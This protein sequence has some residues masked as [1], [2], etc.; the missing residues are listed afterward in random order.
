MGQRTRRRLIQI[1]GPAPLRNEDGPVWNRGRPGEQ[2]DAL[3][4]RLLD[5]ELGTCPTPKTSWPNGAKRERTRLHL[6][7][8]LLDK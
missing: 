8:K 3:F 2:P 7:T 1:R 4:S 5:T 6:H